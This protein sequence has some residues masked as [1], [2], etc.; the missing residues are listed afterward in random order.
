[1]GSIYGLSMGL[2]TRMRVAITGGTGTLGRALISRFLTDGYG[3]V[4]SVSREEVKAGDLQDAY[5]DHPALRVFLGDVRDRDRLKQAFTGCDTVIHAA[6]LKRVM[7]GSY[8][9][10]EIILTNIQGT[11]NAIWAAK[12]AGVKRLLL[13]SSDKAVHATNLYGATKFAAECY[14]TQSNSYTYPAGLRVA[15][16]RYGNVLGSRGSVLEIWSRIA[17]VTPIPITHPQMTRFVI[18]QTDAVDFILRSLKLMQGG[19]IFVPRLKAMRIADL[20]TALYPGRE[21]T[22][23]GLRPGGEK[24]HEV[25]ISDEEQG[26][27][28][29]TPR[30]D[31]VILPS[32]R[33]WSN[34]SY[35]YTPLHGMSRYGSD[36][37]PL[38]TTRELGELCQ[39]L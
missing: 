23:T 34:V 19:E 24:L 37:V 16:T 21:V 1:M 36:T 32:F 5:P 22:L 30:N 26:R 4:V 12:E 15:C 29:F 17:G 14:A 33:P 13:I 27:V 35:G 7:T 11:V 10:L 8:S 28:W 20:A 9:P 6:A 39:N 31:Y 25:L 3:R 2:L 18:T 38:Y